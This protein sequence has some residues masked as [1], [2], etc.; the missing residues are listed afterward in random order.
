MEQI[1]IIVFKENTQKIYMHVLVFLPKKK[2]KK[3]YTCT[4]YYLQ[5]DTTILEKLKGKGF[6]PHFSW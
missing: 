6:V 3:K 1:K 4:S 5:Y 2:K